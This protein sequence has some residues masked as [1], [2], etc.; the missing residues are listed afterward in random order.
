MYKCVDLAFCPYPG[1]TISVGIA[2][3]T[4]RAEELIWQPEHEQFRCDVES[5]FLDES[6]ARDGA[7]TIK[8]LVEHNEADGWRLVDE[9]AKKKY[10]LLRPNS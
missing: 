8:Q 10:F 5:D 3:S 7:Q 1:L 6:I 2:P 9:S 4:V